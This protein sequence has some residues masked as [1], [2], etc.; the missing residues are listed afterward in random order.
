MPSKSP[1]NRIWD[2][3]EALVVELEQSA[4]GLDASDKFYS[5]AVQSFSE[6]ECTAAALS[7]IEDGASI[8]LARSSDD[9]C[10]I[11]FDIVISDALSINATDAMPASHWQRSNTASA[12][13]ST[14]TLTVVQHVHADVRLVLSIQWQDEKADSIHEPSRR[15]TVTDVA[16]AVIEFASAVYLRH[17]Y[18]IARQQDAVR[19]TRE[20]TIAAFND[21]ATLKES[22]FKIATAWASH[23][24][25]DRVSILR[26]ARSQCEL[27]VTSCN[28]SVDLR[29]RQAILLK[30]F[31][32]QASAHNEPIAF[33]VGL[34]APRNTPWQLALDRYVAESGCRHIESDCIVDHHQTCEPKAIIVTEWF[35]A[36]PHVTDSSML[37]YASLA[38]HAALLRDAATWP[39]ALHRA[40]HLLRSRKFATFGSAIAGLLLVLWLVPASFTIPADGRVVPEVHRR[41]FAPADAVVKGIGVRNGES[42]EEGDKLVAL[43]SASI[44]LREEELRGALATARTQ[45]ASLGASRLGPKR[46]IGDA[47]TDSQGVS[48]SEESLKTE[49]DGITK[50]LALVEKQQ[51]DLQILSPIQGQVDRWDLEQALTM[52]PVAQGQYLLDVYSSSGSW[53][54]ELEILDKDATYLNAAHGKNL[55]VHFHLQSQPGKAYQ[56]TIEKIS[57][58][59]NL[60]AEGRSV[61]RL[62]C[63]FTPESPEL[64]EIGATVWAN[65]DCGKRSVG[66]IWLR[67]L[68]EWWERQSWY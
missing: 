58:S 36:L 49:I 11:A 5:L 28:E 14:Q 30:D 12:T 50:Q 2:H 18:V 45:L 40:K 57:E 32:K 54:A 61:I 67:G 65:V 7:V 25:A 10:D 44:D 46:G 39:A 19:E 1:S 26:V 35:D 51:R 33:T 47:A 63:L 24:S 16:L 3:A 8:C 13:A 59:A 9:A 41:L 6:F 4:R 37:E 60:D 27:L 66:F 23:A 15:L 21:G 43:R 48:S 29:S 17:H 53:V 38:I 55:R 62:K 52:R 42:V 31:A 34:S 64:I 22:L 20:R 56:A 68:I